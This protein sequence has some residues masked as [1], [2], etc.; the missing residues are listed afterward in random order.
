M[1]VFVATSDHGLEWWHIK[2]EFYAPVVLEQGLWNNTSQVCPEG[3][4]IP[5]KMVGVAGGMERTRWNR[6]PVTNQLAI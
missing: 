1:D 5:R 2:P 4:R 3:P 6:I